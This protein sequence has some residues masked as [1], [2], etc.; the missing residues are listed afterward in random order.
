MDVGRPVR[1]RIV[2]P[3]EDPVPREAPAPPAPEPTPAEPVP[4]GAPAP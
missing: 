3:V 4:A 2:E 1:I